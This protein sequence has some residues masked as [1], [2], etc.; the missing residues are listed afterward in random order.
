[1]RVTVFEGNPAPTD[2]LG[3]APSGGRIYPVV[4]DP[5]APNTRV[6]LGGMR[7]PMTSYLFWH[8]ISRLGVHPEND[9][10]MLDFPNAGKVPTLFSRRDSRIYG[11]WG[12]GSTA[13]PSD[14]QAIATR[15]IQK[16]LNYVPPRPADAINTDAT[17]VTAATIAGLM[18]DQSKLDSAAKV[19]MVRAWWN[20][21]ARDLNQRSYK[22]YLRQAPDP[23]S[24]ADVELAG[25]VGFGTGGFWTLFQTSA[26]EIMRL[27]LWDYSAE[28]Q[29]PELYRLPY[30]LMQRCQA[31]GVTLVY[32]SS[33]RGFYHVGS[34]GK[35]A[36][37]HGEGPTAVQDFDQVVV[38]TSF[39]AARALLDSSLANKPVAA[40]QLG[41]STLVVPYVDTAARPGYTSMFQL[42][43]FNN[44]GLSSLKVFSTI[45]G[46][47]GMADPGKYLR[48]RA[49]GNPNAY[50]AETGTFFGA[51]K[52][53]VTY[54]MPKDGQLLHEATTAI[55][56]NYAW[57]TQADAYY[58]SDFQNHPLVGPS[59]NATGVF[60]GT[61]PNG[62]FAA[63][64]A[65]TVSELRSGAGDAESIENWS[66][67]V[68]VFGGFSDAWK[69]GANNPSRW[70][71]IHWNNVP[72]CRMGFKLDFPGKGKWS[73]YSFQ[74]SALSTIAYRSGA[75]EFTA[76][77]GSAGSFSVPGDYP[78]MKKSRATAGIYFAGESFSHY[79]GWMEGALQSALSN[80]MALYYA[81]VK[82][83]NQ[84][85]VYAGGDVT[86]TAAWNG[87]FGGLE[88]ARRLWTSD[89][90][91][92]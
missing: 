80:A 57:T 86:T 20:W 19:E 47:A 76:W 77:D 22:D 35:H 36:V 38:A 89:A 67:P 66:N 83:T 28:F 29:L 70:G 53:G 79:G 23:F 8:Y 85:V 75:P 44:Q 3:T 52:V 64:I 48:V 34:S 81:A 30:E 82:G 16:F 56:L 26:L 68:G 15:Q 54:H 24:D 87:L 40:G 72:W 65:Q 13:L 6:E 31:S 45:T 11:T 73:A 91:I 25:D 10:P 49:L 71:I 62:G 92:R 43:D 32:G 61:D 17:G 58:A 7:F 14:V 37:L 88:A 60:I 84:D 46:P 21:A 39:K 12:Q 59:L 63:R 42:G 90:L 9:D 2:V 4:L 74:S 50:Y 33:V 27:V 5:A 1:M 51:S 18:S 78:F 41:N 69:K 55:G